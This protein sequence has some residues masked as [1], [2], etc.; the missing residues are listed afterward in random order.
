MYHFSPVREWIQWYRWHQLQWF[1]L[2]SHRYCTKRPAKHFTFH[3]SF[4]LSF[5][6]KHIVI[7]KFASGI[8]FASDQAFDQL[9]WDWGRH[10]TRY[11][12]VI[13]A[14]VSSA[15]SANWKKKIYCLPRD[16][17][18]KLSHSKKVCSLDK[19]TNLN[20]KLFLWS[21]TFSQKQNGA[22]YAF[23]RCVKTYKSSTFLQHVE[24]IP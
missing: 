4:L 6:S 24:Q 23:S 9:N 12:S 1:I 20:L 22:F 17:K 16:T 3:F 11:S 19:K 15:T 2:N 7:N 21:P 5:S 13:D 8:L 10:R 18:P 14:D